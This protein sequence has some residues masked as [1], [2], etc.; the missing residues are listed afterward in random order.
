M[1]RVGE[2]PE[3]VLRAEGGVWGGVWGGGES[4]TGWRGGGGR[5]IGAGEPAAVSLRAKAQ[6]KAGPAGDR[7]TTQST[8][9]ARRVSR[10]HRE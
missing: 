5:V 9:T 2:V 10:A 6:S 8:K 1:Y 7:R 4:V 3:A